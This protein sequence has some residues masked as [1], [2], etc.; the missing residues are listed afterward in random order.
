MK[1][2]ALFFI[3]MTAFAV[4]CASTMTL[5][6]DD[7][8]LILT[9]TSATATTVTDDIPITTAS[10]ATTITSPYCYECAT[11]VRLFY[12]EIVIEYGKAFDFAPL[13]FTDA[14]FDARIEIWGEEELTADIDY[15]GNFEGR[16]ASCVFVWLSVSPGHFIVTNWNPE[17]L[18]ITEI[19]LFLN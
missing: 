1:R 5:T 7:P 3:I 12:G 9:L 16:F 18:S 13:F 17:P 15:Y 19:N 8:P 11:R 10:T 14:F 2:L 4:G 6:A